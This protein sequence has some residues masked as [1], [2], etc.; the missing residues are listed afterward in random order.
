VNNIIRIGMDTSKHVFQLHGVNAAE[1][2]VLRKTMRRKEMIAFFAKLPPT[3][4]AIEACGASHNWGRLLSSFGHD[5]KLIPPAY[6]KPYIKRGK[7]D[8]ADAEAIC[9]AMSRPAMRF[10]PIKSADNQAALML[11]TMRD[12]LI[13]TRTQLCSA[14]RGHAAEFGLI[15]GAGTCRVEPL[16]DR[17]ACDPDVPELARDLFALHAEELALLR[18]RIKDV[19]ARLAA[20]HRAD[21]RSRRIASIPGVGTLGATLLALKTPAPE[22]FKSGRAFAAWIGLTPRDHSTGGRVKLGSITRAGDALLRRTL[23]VGATAL[24]RHIRN[25]RSKHASPW[26]LEM[27]KRKPPKLVAV[28]LA[29]KM[30]RIAWKLMVTDQQYRAP[31]AAKPLASAA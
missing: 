15:A 31:A 1:E 3:K 13:R 11:V 6:I 22:D 2:P 25:N 30:A 5:V 19:D 24:L 9:E 4:V 23:V 14:I 29:N 27:L 10:V 8:A 17:I 20:W 28:A 7:N 26:I 16:L 18:A 12:R 21:A